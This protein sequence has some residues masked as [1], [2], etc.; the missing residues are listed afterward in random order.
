MTFPRTLMSNHP[1]QVRDW[2]V[3]SCLRYSTSILWNMT[4]AE[5]LGDELKCDNRSNNQT[6]TR[7]DSSFFLSF[8]FAKLVH[9]LVQVTVLRRISAR[10]LLPLCRC[11]AIIVLPCPTHESVTMRFVSL[12][13]MYRSPAC[14]FSPFL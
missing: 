13:C 4:T 7:F 5:S 10:A 11:T 12:S 8:F 3:G 14:L 2:D 1:T 6:T 9:A